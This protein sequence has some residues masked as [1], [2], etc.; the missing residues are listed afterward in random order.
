MSNALEL[1]QQIA[2]HSCCAQRHRNKFI[3]GGLAQSLAIRWLT[4]ILVF[5]YGEDSPEVQSL[6]QEGVLPCILEGGSR[7]PLVCD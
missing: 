1:L 2:E 3:G 7:L 4:E 6:K 5:E